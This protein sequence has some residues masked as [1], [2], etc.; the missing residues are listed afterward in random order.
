[1]NRFKRACV[2]LIATLL[3]NGCGAIELAYNNAPTL[4]ASEFD[5]AF[6]LT[7]AQS[8]KLDTRL[9]RFFA[10]HRQHELS[11][12]RE[13]LD[14]TALTI[15]DGITAAEFLQLRDE[16]RVTWQRSLAQAIDELVDLAPTLTP[17]QIDHFQQYLQD[18][19][20]KYSDYVEMSDQQREIYSVERGLRRIKSWFGDIDEFQKDAFIRRL[21]QLPESRMAWIGFRA[22][23][24]QALLAALREAPEKGLTGEQLKF[25]LMDPNSDHAHRF[26]PARK[27]YWQS[28]A[29]AIED[30]SRKLD[31]DQLRHAVERLEYFSEIVEALATRD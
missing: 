16:F 18:R 30:I 22:E 31:K 24:Q 15:A 3:L 9:Q 27:A 13:F 2:L 17:Q 5:D 25:I 19:S 28:Y 14:S 20:E 8:E 23:V 11:R 21:Q 29:L 1:M 12:Y 6:E 4:V 26:A 7:D 10:W